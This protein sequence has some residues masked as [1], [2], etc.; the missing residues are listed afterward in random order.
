MALA[1]GADLEPL[2]GIV[3]VGVD[4]DAQ[5]AAE[6]VVEGRDPGAQ[7]R[8]A[9]DSEADLEARPASRPVEALDGPRVA[10]YRNPRIMLLRLQ[11]GSDD[12]IIM[13]LRLQT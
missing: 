3:E 6:G 12:R 9:V 11:P 2:P 10:P 5:P 4:E 1:I 7:A 8:G 13:L